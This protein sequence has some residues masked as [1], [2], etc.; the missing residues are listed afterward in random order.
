M[1]QTLD[2]LPDADRQVLWMRHF[3][4]L[5][6][7]E[8][9]EFLGVSE[10]AAAQRYVRALRKLRAVWATPESAGGGAA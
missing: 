6:L 7:R 3:D 5:S 2:R 9:A 4:E 1:R 10:N 8:I